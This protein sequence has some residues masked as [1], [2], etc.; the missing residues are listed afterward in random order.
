M[1]A[2]IYAKIFLFTWIIFCVLQMTAAAGME[3]SVERRALAV[4]LCK[5]RVHFGAARLSSGHWLRLV[6]VLRQQWRWRGCRVLQQYCECRFCLL[7]WRL[8]VAACNWVV[9]LSWAGRVTF[10]LVYLLRM[11]LLCDFFCTHV[12]LI[13]L[14][15]F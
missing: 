11:Y 13:N 4:Q 2:E 14:H 5:L 1:Q 7:C 10:S 15:L 3:R 6:R 8:A 12:V 9:K